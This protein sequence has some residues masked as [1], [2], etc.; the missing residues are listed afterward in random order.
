MDGKT[1]VIPRGSGGQRL[2]DLLRGIGADMSLPCGGHGVCRKCRV[3]VIRGRFLSVSDGVTPLLPD[4]NGYILA[5]RAITTDDGGEIEIYQN[6][7]RTLKKLAPSYFG[8]VDAALDLGT[9]TLNMRFLSESG[10]ILAEM[11]ALNPQSAYGADVITRI[12]KSKKH[13]FDL[14]RLV[15][16]EVKNTADEFAA[17]YKNICFNKLTVA[18]NPTMLHIFRGISPESMGAHPF[19]P[20]FTDCTVIDG[21]DLGLPFE[22]VVL[23]PCASAFI[24]ADAVC[25]AVFCGMTK[26]SKPSLLIDIGTN[27]EMI[28]CTGALSE[29]R[30]FAASAAAGPALEGANISCGTGGVAGAIDRVTPV[31][32]RLAYT[33]V[34]AAPPTGICGGGLVDL[35]AC[36]LDQGE[37]DETGRM[38][39]TFKFDGT[40][41]YLTQEDVREF[42]L[43]KSAIR[44]GLDI[45]LKAA[46]LKPSDV[47]H[48]FIAGGLGYYIGIPSAVRTG[49]LPREFLPIAKAVGNTSLSGACACVND[50]RLK[51]VCDTAKKIK[52]VE[53]N[54]C[55]DFAPLFAKH[56]MF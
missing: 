6:A 32:G 53:L 23:L 7:G 15:F 45:L 1:V 22:S 20:A 28:L 40:N 33:T 21:G 3:R 46:G 39:G 30:L 14:Q 10:D 5:C 44:A 55:A 43:A 50:R 2:A 37:I 34:D 12:S 16:S 9:T 19:T 31:N 47:G 11:S 4:E 41:V 25:G 51:E 56:M 26:L 27:G 18:G 54:G 52:A 35:I 29:S 49:I 8:A 48:V 17:E 38:D 13:L 24:G 42:Q 36:L